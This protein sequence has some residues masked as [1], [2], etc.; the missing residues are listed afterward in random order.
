[1]CPHLLCW[2]LIWR[3]RLVPGATQILERLLIQ[4]I[5]AHSELSLCDAAVAWLHS[6]KLLAGCS[7]HHLASVAIIAYAEDL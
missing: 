5:Q 1:M 3:C 2:S 7:R 6:C 4:A